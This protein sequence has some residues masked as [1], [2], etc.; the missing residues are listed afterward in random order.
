[1]LAGQQTA[2]V[3][4]FTLFGLGIAVVAPVTFSAAGN[5]PGIPSATAISRVTGTGYLGL[6][7]GPP[8]IGFVAQLCGLRAALLIPAALSAL[9]ALLAPTARFAAR[10]QD[11]AAAGRPDVS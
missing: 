9:I 8:A 7:A 10:R 3:A 4:G 6:L 11:R 2:A 1:L 5:L